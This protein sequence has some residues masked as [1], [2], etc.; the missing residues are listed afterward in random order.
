MAT[1][2]VFNR[3]VEAARHERVSQW[4]MIEAIALD[5]A[6]NA[7]PITGIDSIVAAKSAFESAGV[8]YSQNTV[9]ALCLVAKFDHESTA[10]QRTV[11]RS[12]GWSV[13]QRVA[14]AGW[15][16]EAAAAFLSEGRR[17]HKDVTEA[18]KRA[19]VGTRTGDKAR[20]R[21]DLVADWEQ[22]LNRLNVVLTDCARLAEE[23]DNLGIDLGGYAAF[24]RLI[25]ERITERKLDAEIREF[26]TTQEAAH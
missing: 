11:F 15:S 10:A 8:D 4:Q 19:N 23:T 3:T 12:Y 24:A 2:P 14:S 1:G 17:S 16:Q 18:V 6:D 13:V 26:L 25:Y 7:L 9:R 21:D 20:T 5:A 22:S